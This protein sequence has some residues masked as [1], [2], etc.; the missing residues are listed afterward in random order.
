MLLQSITPA[1]VT[2]FSREVIATPAYASQE[3]ET[4]EQKISRVAL[5]HNI[6]S[7]TLFNLAMGESSLDPLKEGDMGV[8][9]PIGVNKDK[10][11]RAKGLVQITDCYQPEITD[12]Q[13]FNPDWALNWAADKIAKGEAWKTWTLCNCYSYSKTQVHN[14]SS[15]KEIQPNTQ[16]PRVGGLVI[17]YFNKVKHLS[18]IEKVTKEGIWVSQTNKTPCKY[19]EELLPWQDPNREGYWSNV[20]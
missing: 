18:V 12:E 8:L 11:I 13:A 19:S 4:V 10:P 1:S 16:Y 5:E 14:L 7:T 20:E 9:C 17:Q 6:A 3:V 2:E 15:L